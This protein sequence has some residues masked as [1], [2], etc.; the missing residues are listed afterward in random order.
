MKKVI[1]EYGFLEYH[2]RGY[3][4]VNHGYHPP[5]QRIWWEAVNT[6]TDC[7]DHHSNTKRDLKKLIDEH[8]D[9]VGFIAS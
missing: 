2:Y 3:R 9:A 6:I 7:S 4:V 5:D 1:N 8:G